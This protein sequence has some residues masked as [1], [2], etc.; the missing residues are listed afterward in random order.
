M[1]TESAGGEEVLEDVEISIPTENEVIEAVLI[2]LE[3]IFGVC[4]N[5]LYI[6]CV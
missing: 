5:S 2:S 1:Q 6:L 3:T 4:W